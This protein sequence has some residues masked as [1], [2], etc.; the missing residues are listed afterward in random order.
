MLRTAHWKCRTQKIAKNWP[1][2]HHCTTL[3]GCI[4]ATKACID[5]RK[6]HVKQQC[7][8]TCPHNMVKLQPS[9]SCDLLASFWHPCRF[10]RVSRLG[11]VTVR[12]SSS[13]RQP[14][15]AALNRGCHLYSAWLPSRWALAHI[16]SL[17]KVLMLLHKSRVV[18]VQPC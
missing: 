8:P 4:F 18:V 16:S 15:F 9:S 11:S 7:P 3:L 17:K 6:K 5:N 2:G 14:N 1:F 13:G 10:H 12:H